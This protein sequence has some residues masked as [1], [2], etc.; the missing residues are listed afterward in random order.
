VG[1]N[2]KKR[3]V[4]IRWALLIKSYL[5]L[6]VILRIVEGMHLIDPE[7]LLV[8]CIEPQCKTH[9]QANKEEYQVFLVHLT[10]P[11]NY[12]NYLDSSFT[13]H[14]TAEPPEISQL[15][16]QSLFLLAIEGPREKGTWKHR[17]ETY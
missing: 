7:G 3:W 16:N 5:T 14:P 13:Y 4:K 8:E 17:W 12:P 11:Q 6:K 15:A 9:N 1:Q 2:K 10:H